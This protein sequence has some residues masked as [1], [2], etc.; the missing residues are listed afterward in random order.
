VRISE[1]EPGNPGLTLV[2]VLEGS[3]PM[4]FTLAQGSLEDAGIPFIIVPDQFSG[5]V[6]AVS[7]PFQ[8]RRIQVASDREAEARALLERLQQPTQQPG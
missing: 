2:T 1:P 3:D 6:P 8:T 5:H 4:V 7:L